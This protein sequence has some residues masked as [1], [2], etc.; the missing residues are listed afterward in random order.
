MTYWFPQYY[1]ACA[2]K[3]IFSW[4]SRSRSRSAP[5]SRARCSASTARWVFMAGTLFL[6]EGLP[7]IVGSHYRVLLPDRPAQGREV[8]HRGRADDAHRRLEARRGRARPPRAAHRPRRHA[9]DPDQDFQLI[10]R[11]WCLIGNASW[12]SARG[13]C[14]S[15][16]SS[17]APACPID[18]PHH[19]RPVDRRGS[20]AAVDATPTAPRSGSGIASCRCWPA[21]WAGL[22][23][24][25][26]FARMAAQ[27]LVSLLF[28]PSRRGRSISPCPSPLMVLPPGAHAAGIAY[29]NVIGIAGTAVTP[30]I[31]GVMKD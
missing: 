10:C 26:H 27:R 21:P 20:D 23:A 19:R 24:R 8:A 5:S 16:A 13:C 12:R 6:I 11:L 9:R 29:L 1:R 14:R 18:R 4:R 17:T 31:M 25:A 7:S 28:V 22:M 3:K 15:S 30:L 2:H